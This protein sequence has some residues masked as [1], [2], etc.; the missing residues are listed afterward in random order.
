MSYEP[1][2]RRASGKKDKST[3][4]TAKRGT[5][6]SHESAEQDTNREV[7]TVADVTVVDHKI[8]ETDREHLEFKLKVVVTTEID[9]PNAS[10]YIWKRW[11]DFV[12][13][14]KLLTKKFPRL[15]IVLL[16]KPT[17]GLMQGKFDLRYV[18]LKKSA[19]HT[20]VQG[21]F[22]HKEV[23]RCDEFVD[24][25]TTSGSKVTTPEAEAATL[26]AISNILKDQE[27]ANCSIKPGFVHNVFVAI[28]G[29]ENILVWE[30]KSI[31]YDM[32]CS[33]NF[34]PAVANSSTTVVMP[35][36]RY[37]AQHKHVQLTY[38]PPCAGEVTI[39]FDNSYSKINAKKMKY[40]LKV[41][42]QTD[43]D[44]ALK[45]IEEEFNKEAANMTK[46]DV[47]DSSASSAEEDDD[48]DG[49]AIE[50]SSSPIDDQGGILALR[51]G[52]KNSD[53][54]RSQRRRTTVKVKRASI[55]GQSNSLELQE[56]NAEDGENGDNVVKVNAIKGFGTN[57]KKITTTTVKDSK[58]HYEIESMRKEN[59]EQKVSLQEADSEIER[60]NRRLQELELEIDEVVD[61]SRQRQE[62]V[63]RLESANVALCEES[64][65]ALEKM[66]EAEKRAEE[67]ERLHEICL[68]ETDLHKQ[69]I[70][71]LTERLIH[72]MEDT[73]TEK[74][75]LNETIEY[76]QEEIKVFE[77]SPQKLK[78]TVNM[79][80][81]LRLHAEAERV[82]AMNTAAKWQAE[83]D[84]KSKLIDSLT[85]RLTLVTN[86]KKILIKAVENYRKQIN[87]R[88]FEVGGRVNGESSNQKA[89]KVRKG[90]LSNVIDPSSLQIAQMKLR[91]VDPEVMKRTERVRKGI[92]LDRSASF[93]SPNG[94]STTMPQSTT[95]KDTRRNTPIF[96]EEIFD[97]GKSQPLA[98][99]QKPD[100]D[101]KRRKSALQKA[102]DAY[103]KSGAVGIIKSLSSTISDEG[104]AMLKG[105]AD[106]VVLTLNSNSTSP[107]QTSRK[108]VK[109]AID[110]G[111]LGTP[112]MSILIQKHIC[113]G[114][115]NHRKIIYNIWGHILDQKPIEEIQSIHKGGIEIC[116][117]AFEHAMAFLDVFIPH[118]RSC[119]RDMSFKAQ[120]VEYDCKWNSKQKNVWLEPLGKSALG[121]KTL[122]NVRIGMTK[123]SA[124]PERQRRLS[125]G[126]YD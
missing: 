66:L 14:G 27:F 3:H 64:D 56:D 24:F 112:A 116:K 83:A 51:S 35:L 58:L 61:E 5:I 87:D 110:W 86:Q 90:R 95:A 119:R 115:D 42:N 74:A 117:V 53:S 30:F 52:R 17:R 26:S 70:K 72:T 1:K 77:S 81:N 75:A 19:V 85:S 31:K 104:P 108:L 10:L 28:E 48:V 88:S 125:K 109:K 7:G 118:M 33:V 62:N 55:F 103:E 120:W 23:V 113:K 49:S 98:Q 34:K 63:A 106:K 13:V 100:S 96:G 9:E 122:I 82:A 79:E 60:L 68:E 39:V 92:G 54:K 94:S 78:E 46:P 89:V 124:Q 29:S 45:R 4:G 107:K 101:S 80:R 41:I 40:R 84:E 8:V 65:N 121:N 93:S 21:L 99:S 76:L 12:D 36:S 126:R 18:N 43:A 91:E 105:V 67:A 111:P 59:E 73:E 15:K 71:E 123:K 44:Q 37:P 16:S 25:V 114:N 47:R 20:F 102:S 38:A 32:G 97:I 69:Q 57:G 22:T 2:A 6:F 11:T 50:I